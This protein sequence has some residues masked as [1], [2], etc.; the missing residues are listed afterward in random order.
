MQNS[1]LTSPL[2]SR[3]DIIF[4]ITDILNSEADS[5][6]CDYILGKFLPNNKKEAN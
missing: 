3:F 1:G 2:L 6:N 4:I 5:D